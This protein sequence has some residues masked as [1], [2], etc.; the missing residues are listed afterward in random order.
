MIEV[1]DAWEAIEGPPA[2]KAKTPIEDIDDGIEKSGSVIE[3]KI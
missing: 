2:P 1:K 3:L